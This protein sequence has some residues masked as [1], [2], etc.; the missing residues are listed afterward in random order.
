M[1]AQTA[2]RLT[3]RYRPAKKVADSSGKKGEAK[4]ALYAV[5]E[6][7]LSGFLENEPDI[8][9]VVDVKVRYQ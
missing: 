9:A 2:S 4:D 6:N 3:K 5:E 7:S 8:Y 1:T